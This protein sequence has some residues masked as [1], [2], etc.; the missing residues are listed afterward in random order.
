MK[1]I[2][3]FGIGK[4]EKY[5]KRCLIAE[6]VIVKGYIDNYKYES[7]KIYNG[8]SVIKQDDI[9]EDFDYII[10]TLMQYESVKKNLIENGIDKNKIIC[11]FDFIAASSEVYSDIIDSYK[12]KTELMF[13][14]Y[15]EIVV[16]SMNNLQYELYF[17]SNEMKR[18]FPKIIDVDETVR[19]IKKYKKSLARLGDGEFELIFGRCRANFQDVDFLLA[20][21]LKETLNSQRDNLL[22]AIADIYG[23][24]DKYTDESANNIRTYLT[25]SVRREHMSLLDLNR[26]YYNAYISR[27]YII[28]RNKETALKKFQNIREIWSNKDILIVEG[29][30]TR[31]GVG[32]DLIANANSVERIICP[33]K[34]AFNMY[35]IIKEK[36]LE[37]GKNKLILTT[38]GTTAT[39]LACDV[40]KE[41]GY[42]IIDIGQLDTEYEW[43]LKGVSERCR[44]ENKNVSEVFSYIPIN[45]NYKDEN[46][47][48]YEEQIIY[49]ID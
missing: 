27:P 22:V 8:Y 4:G 1:K 26:Y 16:P 2:Y 32:N 30:H 45:D 37:F 24:L 36:T 12:W 3:V 23:K 39:V 7:L 13:K 15:Y 25:S 33:D 43:F 14:H 47:K 29:K 10:I 11:F 28:Y 40:S 44:I 6:N 5:L 31:F 19:V 38:L 42:W 35:K 18:E 20:S 9:K 21:K 46:I 41:N 17:D 48:K 49:K 34:N